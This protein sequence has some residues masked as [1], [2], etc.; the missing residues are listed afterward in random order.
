MGRMVSNELLIKRA[1]EES[2]DH[3][4]GKV[5]K[6]T[7]VKKSD[8]SGMSFEGVVLEK[9]GE[10]VKWKNKYEALFRRVT[11]SW[12]TRDRPPG[13][14]S[15][16]SGEGGGQDAKSR[17]R[18][19]IGGKRKDGERKKEKTKKREE[20]RSATHL[21]G[22]EFIL[23]NDLDCKKHKCPGSA[24]FDPSKLPRVRIGHEL[25]SHL[26]ST[27]LVHRLVNV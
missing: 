14:C 4:K 5:K 15:G 3:A 27:Q 2:K 23:A 18:R 1:G 21:R 12:R 6:E 25:T 9:T 26:L 24:L 11:E 16:H 10:Y 20:R 22:V 17:T 7:K 8:R 13:N 19:E